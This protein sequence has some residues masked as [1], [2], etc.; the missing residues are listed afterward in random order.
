MLNLKPSRCLDIWPYL[1]QILLV[2]C[3]SK[4]KQDFNLEIKSLDDTS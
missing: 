3:E 1:A 4:A 2:T